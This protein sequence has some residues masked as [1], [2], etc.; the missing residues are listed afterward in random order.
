LS[1]FS[2]ILVQFYSVLFLGLIIAMSFMQCYNASLLREVPYNYIFLA[3]FTVSLSYMLGMISAFHSIQA[4]LVTIGI[5]FFVTLGVTIFACQTKFDFTSSI[6]IYLVMLVLS[7]VV[8]GCAMGIVYFCGGIVMHGVYG[9]AGAV[10]M[11]L[12]LAYDTQMIIGNKEYNYGPEDYVNAALQIY[13]D[14]C[15]LFLY[16]LQIVGGGES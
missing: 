11:A 14:V 3:A 15:N 2:K 1:D 16:I 8:W 7:L 10:L 9:G 12:F 5:T 13:L 6:A 4:V